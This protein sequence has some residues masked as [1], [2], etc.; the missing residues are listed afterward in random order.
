MASRHRKVEDRMR[1]PAAAAC[2]RSVCVLGR[3]GHTPFV[4]ATA[5][6]IWVVR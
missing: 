4:V 5:D 2:M 3:A 1:I 6:E